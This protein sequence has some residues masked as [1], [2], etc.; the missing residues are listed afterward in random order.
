M[1]DPQS[2]RAWRFFVGSGSR[3]SVRCFELAQAKMERLRQPAMNPA[4]SSRAKAARV[5]ERLRPAGPSEEVLLAADGGGGR[6]PEA[7]SRGRPEAKRPTSRGTRRGSRP[8]QRGSRRARPPEQG[9]DLQAK[10][11]GSMDPE[12]TRG[13]GHAE[14]K[15][16][17]RLQRRRCGSGRIQ[18]AA[19]PQATMA[20]AET[21]RFGR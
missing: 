7:S 14:Q 5:M 18:L 3:R 1:L 9:H 21:N 12:A 8:R 11:S 4:G 20:T 19:T 16:S 6:R 13:G 2:P 15:G 10:R 17:G